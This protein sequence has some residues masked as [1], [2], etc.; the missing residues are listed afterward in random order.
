MRRISGYQYFLIKGLS[1]LP[2]KPDSRTQ[3]RT[4]LMTGI[5]PMGS[6]AL[7]TTCVP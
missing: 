1:S 2:L 4:R 3:S 5:F 7:E 6:R